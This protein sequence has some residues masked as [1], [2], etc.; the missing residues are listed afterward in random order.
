MSASHDD[1]WEH[2]GDHMVRFV[3][4]DIVHTRSC[5]DVTADHMVATIERFLHYNAQ[6][7]P[8]C[9]LADVS[10]IGRILPKASRISAELGTDL[11]IR[12]MAMIGASFKQRVILILSIKASRLLSS[13]QAIHGP[14]GFFT[15]EEE[16]YAW[17]M[18]ERRK[19][20]I[21]S[22]PLSAP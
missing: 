14:F 4:P 17:F 19:P 18:E 3:A 2:I 10:A 11:R 16:A 15:T 12:A 7:G 20:F 9:W 6:V 5:G 13:K 1:G 21:E 8:L 22:A